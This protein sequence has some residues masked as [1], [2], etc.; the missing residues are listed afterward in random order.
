MENLIFCAVNNKNILCLKQKFL[1]LYTYLK[2]LNVTKL[3]GRTSLDILFCNLPSPNGAKTLGA[4][5][6]VKDCTELITFRSIA[7]MF[8]FY[9]PETFSIFSAKAVIMQQF[10]QCRLYAL[11]S[12]NQNT[13]F[14]IIISMCFHCSLLL[15]KSFYTSQ[16]FFLV[17]NV[18]PVHKKSDKQ[19][20]KN[21]RS[22][23]LLP[24]CGK[25][26]ERLIYNSLFE[27]F[28]ENDLISPNQSGFKPGDP[29]T[30][31]LVSITH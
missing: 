8:H 11:S 16:F 21:Y 18:V 25:V 27:Y 12:L 13:E 30:N 28:I 17:F 4:N 3:F 9:I 14:L 1:Y 7:L 20:L 24:I 19:I 10:V 26:F 23:S 15:Q 6:L 2:Y 5:L 29:C 31:Q 22:V